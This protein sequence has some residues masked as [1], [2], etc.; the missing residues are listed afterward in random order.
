M[1]QHPKVE[2]SLDFEDAI[3][4]FDL[5]GRL[6]EAS[7]P[8]VD[9]AI[10]QQILNNLECCLEAELAEVFSADYRQIVAD[11]RA[12]VATRSGIDG[13]QIGS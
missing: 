12:K 6:T 9:S 4:L 11:C 13:S 5:V 2:L 1:Q 8:D 7:T 10:D 3:A